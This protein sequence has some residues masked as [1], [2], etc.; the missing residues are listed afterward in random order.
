MRLA[1]ASVLALFGAPASAQPLPRCA[2][3]ESTLRRIVREDLPRGLAALAVSV[4]KTLLGQTLAVAAT[5]PALDAAISRGAGA[6]EVSLRPRPG[7]IKVTATSVHGDAREEIGYP[8]PGGRPVTLRVP[9]TAA[10]TG[11]RVASSL[12]PALEAMIAE[13]QRWLPSPLRQR[14]AEVKIAWPVFRVAEQAG[15]I[16]LSWGAWRIDEARLGRLRVVFHEKLLVPGATAA[17][18]AAPTRAAQVRPVAPHEP[19]TDTQFTCGTS[20]AEQILFLSGDDRVLPALSGNAAKLARLEQALA[21]LPAG[22][23]LRV[24]GHTDCQ[25]PMDYN[26]NLSVRRARSVQA[27]LRQKLP[28]LQTDS[29]GRGFTDPF[30]PTRSCRGFAMDADC[31]GKPLAPGDA[32]LA[33]NRMVEFATTATDRCGAR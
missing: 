4:R 1:A 26:M 15:E 16:A 24:I 10:R 18:G 28:R 5:P 13:L 3:A 19:A 8:A 25:G 33:G 27:H 21:T 22:C 14:D 32:C 9:C 31:N 2:D 29:E 20:V 12:R 7:T 23:E 30:Q 17:L 11:G 6:V